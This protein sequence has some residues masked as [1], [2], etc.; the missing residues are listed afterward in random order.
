MLANTTGGF[1]GLLDVGPEAT[2]TDEVGPVVGDKRREGIRNAGVC[3]RAESGTRVW[4]ARRVGPDR[5][6][7]ASRSDGRTRDA[8]DQ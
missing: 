7:R 3:S 5:H 8:S 6:A 4:I 2:G 1:S